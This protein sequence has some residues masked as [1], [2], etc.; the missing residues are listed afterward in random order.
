MTP[1]QRRFKRY[2]PPHM[3][4]MGDANPTLEDFPASQS[5]PFFSCYPDIAI[6]QL[7][8]NL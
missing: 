8:E 2:F 7:A 4:N 1:Q 3:G 5:P 6:P